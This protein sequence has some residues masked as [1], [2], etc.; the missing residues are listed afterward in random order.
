MQM[1]PLVPY[2]RVQSLQQHQRETPSLGLPVPRGKK[3]TDIHRGEEMGQEHRQMTGGVMYDRDTRDVI[4]LQ[5]Y[6]TGGGSG[7]VPIEED[8]VESPQVF[9]YDPVNDRYVKE[10]S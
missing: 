4:Q 2:E 9:V 5:E 3:S 1:Q 6:R 8:G 7:R 10:T